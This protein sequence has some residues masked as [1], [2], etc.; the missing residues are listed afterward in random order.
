M[1]KMSIKQPWVDGLWHMEG[2]SN[3]L[4]KV[5]GGE[6]RWTNLAELEYPDLELSPYIGSWTYGSYKKTPKDIAEKTGADH[7]N[8]EMKHFDGAFTFHGVL[9]E[10]GK[11]IVMHNMSGKLDTMRLLTP[12][13]TKE[14][15]ESRQDQD[16]IIP[17]GFTPQSENQ[18]KILFLSG[19]PGAGKSTTA[20]FLAKEKGYAY[21]EADCYPS[22]VDPFIP[23]D[24]PEPSIAQ[25]NQKPIKVN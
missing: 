5:K 8:L 6:A 20:Q 17:P 2:S 24:V 23:L 4:N 11:S 16:S 22:C 19:P 13:K 12:E 1:S 9:N 18:G 15:L 14:L 10:D 25:M 7:F 21:Y 3:S